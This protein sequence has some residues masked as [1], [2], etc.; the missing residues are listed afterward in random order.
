MRTKNKEGHVGSALRTKNGKSDAPA[1]HP[2]NLEELQS[3]HADLNRRLADAQIPIRHRRKVQALLADVQKTIKAQEKQ[4]AAESGGAAIER[5][6]EL[7]ASADTIA[8][9]AVVMGEIP[10]VDADALRG[11]IDW[12]RQKTPASAVLLVTTDGAK[13]TLIAGMSKDAVKR[14]LKAGDLIKTIAPHVGGRGGGRP[15]MAQGGGNDPEGIPQ[16]LA[17]AQEWAKA[18]LA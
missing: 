17:A 9:V 15:D 16:A 13:V 18:R 1:T 5:A 4:A 12:I 3:A 14:G 6:G 10:N 2:A 11:A 7:L 8:N